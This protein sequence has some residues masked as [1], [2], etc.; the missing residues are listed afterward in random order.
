M[1]RAPSFQ[2]KEIF[3][4]RHNTVNKCACSNSLGKVFSCFNMAMPQR[5]SDKE[6]DTPS[7]VE[8]LDPPTQSP[9][10][11]PANHWDELECRL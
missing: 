11:N 6:M 2:L 5:Q 3:T 9:D 4:L 8:E 1:D 7:A 10:L